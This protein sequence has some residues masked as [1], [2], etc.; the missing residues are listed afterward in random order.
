HVHAVNEHTIGILKNQWQIL[1]H[2]PNR[3]QPKKLHADHACAMN[4][5]HACIILHNFL[6]EER[7]VLEEYL[8]S[9]DTEDNEDMYHNPQNPA[10]PPGP[11]LDGPAFCQS[12][13][14]RA[15]EAG[16][17]EHGIFTY[18]QQQQ[19]EERQTQQ[20]QEDY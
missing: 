18:E 16:Y 13:M 2:L 9:E 20:Q 8:H 15:I 19:E 3:I 1:T 11:P 10:S 6:H 14:T 17:S 12:L 4:T 5:I 7:D